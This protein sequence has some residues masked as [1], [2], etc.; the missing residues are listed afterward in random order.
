MIRT[1]FDEVITRFEIKG[2][3]KMTRLKQIKHSANI[4]VPNRLLPNKTVLKREIQKKSAF[5]TELQDHVQ[6][7]DQNE[8]QLNF[9]NTTKLN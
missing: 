5:P 6:R 4:F 8:R 3:E 7:V 2:K 9:R 1:D